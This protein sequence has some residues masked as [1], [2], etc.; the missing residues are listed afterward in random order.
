MGDGAAE[1]DLAMLEAIAAKRPA[2]R[3][4]ASFSGPSA[5][6]RSAQAASGEYNIWSHKQ[7][8]RREERQPAKTRVNVARDC[9]RTAGND[10]P[11]AY[12]CLPFA[13]GSCH[14]GPDCRFLHRVPFAADLRRLSQ[15][16]DIFG[17]ER[18]EKNRSDMSGVG[19]W[20]KDQRTLY[21]GRLAPST[22]DQAVRKAFAEFGLLESA[23]VF[24]G[25]GFAFVTY[26]HRGSTE[27]A[28]QAMMD[29]P[30]GEA[31]MINV[32]WA[33]DDPNPGVSSPVSCAAHRPLRGLTQASVPGPQAE[34]EG[35]R[36]GGGGAR[37]ATRR[38]GWRVGG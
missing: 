3:Q 31:K 8:G 19:T 30:L 21:V 38:G 16:E 35:E 36:S 13:K 23:R 37:A 18:H 6:D 27:F 26:R 20:S 9:G 28:L 1:Q 22:T 29:Q 25:R 5:A 24:A 33:Q 17:R 11:A 2:R 10:N 14:K 4:A 34:G 15:T 12:I 7:I 32:R